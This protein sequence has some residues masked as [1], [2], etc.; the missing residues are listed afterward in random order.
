[1]VLLVCMH[2]AQV[3]LVGAFKFPRE[4]NWLSDQIGLGG[5]STGP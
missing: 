2:A 5:H 3:F 1:M 4:L